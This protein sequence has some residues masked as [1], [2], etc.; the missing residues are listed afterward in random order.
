MAYQLPIV[1]EHG[2]PNWPL[3]DYRKEALVG[4]LVGTSNNRRLRWRFRLSL[5]VVRSHVGNTGE[6]LLSLIEENAVGTT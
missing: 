5:E 6:L 1:I 3:V 2:S 4:N